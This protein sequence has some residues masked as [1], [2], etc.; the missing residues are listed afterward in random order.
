MEERKDIK[1]PDPDCAA[2]CANAMNEVCIEKCSPEGNCAFFELRKDLSLPEMPRY[3][4][5]SKKKWKAR[6]VIQEA[7]TSKISDFIQGVSHEPTIRIRRPVSHG[8]RRI[9]VSEDLTSQDLF[10]NTEG[11]DAPHQDR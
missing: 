10:V 6:F 7:Y 2:I 11:E 8:E 1:L 3:P 4:D 5:T 9:A